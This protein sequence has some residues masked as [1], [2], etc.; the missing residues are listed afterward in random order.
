MK[1]L[2]VLVAVFA[3]ALLLNRPGG[4]TPDLRTAGNIGMAAMLLFTSLGHFLFTDGMSRMLPSYVP[5]KRGLVWLTG[6]L[7]IIAAAG[8]LFPATRWATAMCLIAFFLLTLPANIYAALHHVD[9]QHP[10]K[11]G[12]GPRYLWFRVPLQLFFIGWVYYFS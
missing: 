6:G 1:P 5:L 10:D 9:Y 2:F 3:V 7:E 11:R 12:P 8:L 4:N